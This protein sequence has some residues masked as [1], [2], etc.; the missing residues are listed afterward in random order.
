VNYRS[1]SDATIGGKINPAAATSPVA[2]IFGINSYTLVDLRAGIAAEDDRWRVSI[3]GKNV[4]NE[5][6][7]NNVVAA[8]DAIVRYAGKPATYGVSVSFKY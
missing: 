3:W 6:Y 4:F 5:Y 1:K 8:F 7:F 2:T